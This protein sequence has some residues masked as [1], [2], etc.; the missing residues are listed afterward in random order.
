VVDRDFPS[1]ETRGLSRVGRTPPARQIEGRFIDRDFF[2]D[3]P[4]ETAPMNMRRGSR[5][6]HNRFGNGRVLGIVDA[7]EPTVVVEFPGWGEKKILARF[8]KPA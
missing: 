5:V 7:A 3:Q 2:D 4:H 8:L 6:R 1:E